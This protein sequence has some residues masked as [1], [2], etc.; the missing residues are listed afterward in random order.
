MAVWDRIQ[1]GDFDTS[2]FETSE[3]L[4]AAKANSKTKTGKP[5]DLSKK[6]M[7]RIYEQWLIEEYEARE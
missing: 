5:K 2:A 7:Q 6:E 1:R 4:A 3:L